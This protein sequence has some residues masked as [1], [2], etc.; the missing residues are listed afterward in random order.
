MARKNTDKPKKK[1]LFTRIFGN[2][3]A[4]D[5][6]L[7]ESGAAML[8]EKLKSKNSFLS[9]ARDAVS[10]V[11]TENRIKNAIQAFLY[12]LLYIRTR[13]IGIYLLS[14][15]IYSAL[16]YIVMRFAFQR[17]IGMG[18]VY[19]S[20]AL[21]VLSLFFFSGRPLAETVL[22]SKLLSFAVFDLLGADK[23][24]IT[25]GPVQIKNSSI[26][27]LF[28]MATGLCAFLLNPAAVPFAVLSVI[29][30][31]AVLYQPESG[32]VLIAAVLPFVKENVTLA[33]WGFTF[34]SYM[35][36]TVRRKRILRFS[37]IDVSVMMLGAVT[38]LGRVASPGGSSYDGS[39]YAVCIFAYFVCR[40]LL[41]RKEWLYR[42]FSAAAF[43][44]AAV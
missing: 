34:A 24:K 7:K 38:L 12:K 20:A 44:C 32:A 21:T 16:E 10:R 17:D 1:S 33:L 5:K 2:Y 3:Y 37:L 26:A 15:G 43:S 11:F 14:T 4:A 13:D 29:L 18:V 35:L 8:C 19:A 30:L 28:G 27:L 36:K 23:S 9:K 39:L 6:A 40:N 42:A 22:K 25:E 31:I 41:C